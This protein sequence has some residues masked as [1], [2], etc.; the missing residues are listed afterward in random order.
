MIAVNVFDDSR[1]RSRRNRTA[2]HGATRA[3]GAIR[4]RFGK[5]VLSPDGEPESAGTQELEAVPR[6]FRV[7][8]DKSRAWDFEVAICNIKAGLRRARICEI[9]GGS[10]LEH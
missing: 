7:S 9:A 3:A 8:G 2:H 5:T 10:G 4:C 6:R 1:R